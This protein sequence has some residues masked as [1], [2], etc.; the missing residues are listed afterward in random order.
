MP[1]AETI[2]HA[3]KAKETPLTTLAPLTPL[4]L[5]AADPP[6]NAT[7]TTFLTEISDW[8]MTTGVGNNLVPNKNTTFCNDSIFINGTAKLP[9]LAAS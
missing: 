3:I 1:I 8:I 9:S 5:S 2:A 6:T 7:L 4:T